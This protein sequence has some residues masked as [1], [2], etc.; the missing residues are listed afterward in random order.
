MYDIFT[1]MDGWVFNGKI[2]G[3]CAIFHVYFMEKER[4]VLWT[5]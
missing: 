3:K 4:Y 5:Y 2:Y 1:Y